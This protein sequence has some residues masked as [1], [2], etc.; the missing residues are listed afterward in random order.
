M[1]FRLLGPLHVSEDSRELTPRRPRERAVLAAL[2]LRRG[3]VIATDE[4]VDAVWGDDPPP[5][6]RTALHGHISALR[7]LIGAGRLA[8]VGEGYRLDLQSGDSLDVDRVSTLAASAAGQPA[9]RSEALREAVELFRG[10]PFEGLELAADSALAGVLAGEATRLAEQRLLLEELRVSA[11]LE[12]GREADVVPRLERLVAEHPLRESL[13]TALMLALYRTSRQADALRVAQNARHVLAEELG[14][15]PGPALR[16]LESRI[17]DQ[18][19]ALAGQPTGDALTAR[20]IAG[21]PTFLATDAP[22]DEAAS[23][24]ERHGGGVETARGTWTILRFGRARDAAGAA[25]GLARTS[26]QARFG[27]HSARVDAARGEASGPEVERARHIGRI[28]QPGQ[29]VLSRASRD[30]LREAPMA[31]AD[32][33]DL[34]EHRLADLSPP[35]PLFQ[36]VAPGLSVDVAPLRGLETG[37]T[38]LPVQPAPL[39]GRQRE[40]D[41]L[42]DRLR[43]PG[44][45]LVTLTGPGGIGKTR[46]ALHVGAELLDDAS[47]GVHFVALEAIA[48]PRVVAAA[49][50]NAVGVRPAGLEA[51]DAAVARELRDAPVIL[52]VDNFEH[53]LAAAPVVTAI[54]DG[55]HAVKVLATSRTPLGLRGEHVYPVPPLAGP[56][57][58]KSAGVAAEDVPTV[59]SMPAVALFTSRARLAAPDFSLTPSNAAAV[60]ELVGLVDRLPL[61]I[62]LAASRVAVVP[63][64]AM[65]DRIRGSIQVLASSRRPG[66]PRHRALEAT[67]DWSY[68]LLEPEP[69]VLFTDVAVFAGGWTLDAAEQVCEPAGRVIDGLAILADQS[70]VRVSGKDEAPRFAMLETIREHAAAKLNAGGRRAAVEGR[71]AA[72]YSRL[73]EEAA[74][75]LRGNPGAWLG[76]LETERANLRAALDRLA[77]AGDHL[78][79]ATLAG[80][81]WRF[82]YLAGD[83]REGQRRLEVALAAHPDPTRARARALIGAAV[84]AVNLED[85]AGAHRRAAEGLELHETLGDA[86]GAAYCRFMLGA[87]ARGAGDDTAARDLFVTALGTF[88]DLGDKHSALLV[89]RTLAVTLED[90]GDRAAGR[91]LYQ[92]NLRRARADGNGRLEASTLGALATIAF[93][94]GRV[95]DARWMLRESLRLH[96]QLRDRLDTAVD[97]ARAARTLSMAGQPAEAARLVAALARVVSEL[98]ARR[99]SVQAMLDDAIARSR[100]QL[101]ASELERNSL[102]GERLDLDAAL[103]MALEALAEG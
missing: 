54:L 85:M 7:R 61:A 24:G 81:M 76:Q 19:P 101:P 36:L 94:E 72:F 3:R 84:M 18:D 4:L 79:E 1:E 62:E 102:E 32:V 58:G 103:E 27:V 14:I 13:R 73:A 49:I 51:P 41:E 70:L 83:L 6:A 39:I 21:L 40:V 2:L 17:L 35:Q 96:G 31:E 28:A 25:V 11:D 65:L 55:T 10:E 34:G 86:W 71:H 46:L 8:T 38:N 93:E 63:P 22:R 15:E 98:G 88:R 92:D 89:S 20:P 59:A 90:L 12:L 57:G 33:L 69:R 80:A 95:S 67:I 30:L 82:W 99:G 16:H 52:I 50:A 29:V 53:V 37:R 42:A 48:D 100:R 44:V 47:E 97:L 77:A 68:D 78:A 66:P 45:R 75:H 64:A 56:D 43:D 5:T 74:E 9:V 60:S 23:I 87:A 26:R 91:D